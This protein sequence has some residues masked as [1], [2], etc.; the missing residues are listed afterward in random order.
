MRRGRPWPQVRGTRFES[1][2]RNQ[3]AESETR[4]R[5]RVSSFPAQ[6]LLVAILV[7]VG[8]VVLILVLIAIDAGQK[9]GR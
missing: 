2:P 1:V 5:G 7:V 9:H 6:E 3:A 8:V 4:S